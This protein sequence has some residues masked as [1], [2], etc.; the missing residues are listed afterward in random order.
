M[1]L[2]N[3]DVEQYERE[4]KEYDRE[5]SFAFLHPKMHKAKI[6]LLVKAVSWF[7]RNFTCRLF[8]CKIEMESHVTPDYGYEDWWCKRGCGAG[9]RI[10]YY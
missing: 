10:Y 4:M 8:G 7:Q 5:M 1:S 3:A 9:D 2:L 6:F